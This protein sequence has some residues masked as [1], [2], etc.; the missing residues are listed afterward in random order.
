MIDV[1]TRTAWLSISLTR[2]LEACYGASDNSDSDSEA[3]EMCSA[4]T[5]DL[6]ALDPVLAD[7]LADA[8]ALI[9]AD[10]DAGDPPV[11]LRAYV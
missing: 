4:L 9:F 8:V 6:P 10:A 3:S 1:E 5:P 2:D 7:C 11:D